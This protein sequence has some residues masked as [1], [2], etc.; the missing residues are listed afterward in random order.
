MDI[1]VNKQR[2]HLKNIYGPNNDNPNNDNPNNDNPNFFSTIWQDLEPFKNDQYIICGDFHLVLNLNL[3]TKNYLHNNHP[4]AR[5]KLLEYNYRSFRFNRPLK[6]LYPTLNR[7]TCRNPSDGFTERISLIYIPRLYFFLL[8]NS[9]V[10]QVEK[11]LID[12][13][14]RWN[15]VFKNEYNSKG[16]KLCKNY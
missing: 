15:I 12:N 9:L 2:I 14:Y 13:S 5:D 1:T 11:V 7:Y 6:E 4:K 8:S 3:D 16:N 10:P